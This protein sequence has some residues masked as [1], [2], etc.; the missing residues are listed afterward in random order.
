VRTLLRARPRTFALVTL[1]GGLSAALLLYAQAPY[2][3]H[4][5]DIVLAMVPLMAAMGLVEWRAL[6]FR[7]QA[8]VLLTRVR[9]P[10]QFAARV[11]LLLLANTALCTAVVAVLAVGLLVALSRVGDLRPA[12]VAMATAYAVLAGA[13]L[14]TFILAEL[15]RYGGMCLALGG[16]IA[17]HAGA[18]A[19]HP[20]LDATADTALFAGSAVLLQV[21]LLIA[22]APVLGQVWR[23]R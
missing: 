17:A 1:S 16:A 20:H 18:A 7:Q 3:L 22:V 13:Y 8:R 15:G 9:R 4:D 19:M 10:R 14:L 5:L 11:W 2:L 23:Y 6:R 21:L 12:T